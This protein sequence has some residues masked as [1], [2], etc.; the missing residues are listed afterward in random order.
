MGREEGE[1]QEEGVVEGPFLPSMGVG[2][3][4]KDKEEG[5]PLGGGGFGGRGQW[6]E[7]GPE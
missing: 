1:E 5:G 3:R 7:R 2:R 4:Q 6:K